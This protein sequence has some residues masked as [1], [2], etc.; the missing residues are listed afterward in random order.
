MK[1]KTVFAE[2]SDIIGTSN[3][4][5]FSNMVSGPDGTPVFTL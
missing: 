5:Y 2:W 3:E 4:N 1:L